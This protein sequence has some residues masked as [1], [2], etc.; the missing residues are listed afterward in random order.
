[1]LRKKVFFIF[2]F[3]LIIIR[4]LSA[5]RTTIEVSFG[6]YNIRDIRF[7]RVYKESGPIL[8]I[9]VSVSPVSN[10][11]IWLGVKGF[12]K[13]GQLTFTKEE[14]ELILVPISA[15]IKYYRQVGLFK[16]YLGGGIDYY[17]YYEQTPIGDTFD[18]T[19][20]LHF[21]VG[22]YFHV[23]KSLPFWLNLNIK[24]TKAETEE[25]NNKIDLGGLEYGIGLAIIF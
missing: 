4:P 21:Q 14:T 8:G 17:L 11:D 20:G 9:A 22:S 3:I 16:P 25:N 13:S 7:E 2:A 18:Y 19:T 12:Y 23:I 10:F 24:Y 1:M 5:Q 15:G 6:K